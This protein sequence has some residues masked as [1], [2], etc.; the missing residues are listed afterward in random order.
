MCVWIERMTVL[1]TAHAMMVFILECGKQNCPS[2]TKEVE[3]S[4]AIITITKLTYFRHCAKRQYLT[5]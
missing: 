4:Q 2:L 1:T 3:K 5:I